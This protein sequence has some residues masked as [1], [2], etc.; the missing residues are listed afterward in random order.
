MMKNYT[1][2][3]GKKFNE[4]GSFR[5]FPGLTVISKVKINTFESN[6]LNECQQYFMELPFANKFSFLPQNSLHMTVFELVNDQAR[7]PEI[8][9]KYLHLE[10]PM[11]EVD[12][13]IT[14]VW[15][16]IEKPEII[17]MRITGCKVA[18]VIVISLEP[19]TSEDYESL[20]DF[21]DITSEK[22]GVRKPNHDE[23]KY[24]ISFAYKLEE[25]DDEE[26]L[27]INGIIRAIN[28]RL[29]KDISY[30]ELKSPE[31]CFYNDMS[32]FLPIIER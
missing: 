14:K 23:Y 15:N 3:V 24:H 12:N 20:K 10:T 13:F 5:K 6:I 27:L 21:R 31:L 8:W 4:D 1:F 9:S 25:L 30:I 32:A 17:K 2:H 7:I 16:N 28:E 11:N 26:N 29:L 22:T 19:Y 18:S